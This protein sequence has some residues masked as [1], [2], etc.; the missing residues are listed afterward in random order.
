M[1]LYQY[2]KCRDTSSSHLCLWL[3]GKGAVSDEYLFIIYDSMVWY[4]II[5][6]LLG[7]LAWYGVA[8]ARFGN[9]KLIEELRK[10]Y[11]QLN[12]D[13]DVYAKQMQ[14][15]REQ[16]TILKQRAQEMLDQNEDYSKIVSELSRYYY[17]IKQANAKLQ[18][19]S[20]ILG[21]YD[22]GIEKKLL[23]ADKPL[24]AFGGRDSK[25]SAPKKFF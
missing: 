1:S 18:E 7:A 13:V 2:K 11:K 24:S 9:A 4:V 3:R 15:L 5:S 10:N 21:V 17:H 16:N 12:E 22:A 20:D 23:Q 14:E 8:Y 19:L 25:S 6:L